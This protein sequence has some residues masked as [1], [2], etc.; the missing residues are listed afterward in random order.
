MTH[1]CPWPTVMSLWDKGGECVWCYC[2]N[3]LWFIWDFNVGLRQYIIPTSGWHITSQHQWVI[4]DLGKSCEWKRGMFFFFTNSDD[5]TSITCKMTIIKKGTDLDVRRW[6]I[7]ISII[8]LHISPKSLK[9]L[10]LPQTNDKWWSIC[11]IFGDWKGFR[12]RKEIMMMVNTVCVQSNS[13]ML[14]IWWCGVL[15]YCIE[16]QIDFLNSFFSIHY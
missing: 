3:M 16:S 5:D 8:E 10:I 15:S 2:G 13:K 9:M 7:I 12:L 4:L 1:L 11:G 6:T 14:T